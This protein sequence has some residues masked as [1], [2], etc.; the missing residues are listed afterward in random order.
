[1]EDPPQVWPGV[2]GGSPLCPEAGAASAC[3][4]AVTVGGGGFW[5]WLPAHGIN[6]LHLPASKMEAPAQTSAAAVA[7]R[8]R[9]RALQ[10]AAAASRL[11]GV[12]ARRLPIASVC[13]SSS[14][15]T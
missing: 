7:P 1:M 2:G 6:S 12:F 15:R 10:A 11:L 8:Q 9:R 13:L 4:E 14:L 5:A 3:G